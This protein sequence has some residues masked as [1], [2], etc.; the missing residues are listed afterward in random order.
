MHLHKNES[1]GANTMTTEN[2]P[3]QQS[4]E[5]Q[6]IQNKY[7]DRGFQKLSYAEYTALQKK[8]AKKF[9]LKLPS[10]IQFVLGTPFLIIFCFGIFFIPFIYFQTIAHPIKP[11]KK[12]QQVQTKTD[13][14]AP[15]DKLNK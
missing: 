1:K 9:K 8:N 5:Q 14:I 15:N 7:K 12:N 11:N 10:Y 6:S 3:P 2:T 4:Q 13:Q